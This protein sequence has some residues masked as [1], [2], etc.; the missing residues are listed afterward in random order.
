M[1]YAITP[2]RP[3]LAAIAAVLALSATPS[4]AQ[5]ALT[6]DVAPPAV[7]P[8]NATASGAG[9]AGPAIAPPQENAAP[10]LQ[11]SPTDAITASTTAPVAAQPAIP[12]ASSVTT[13][14]PVIA[15]PAPAA[16]VDAPPPPA[17]RTIAQASPSRSA[18]S[19]RV[20][21]GAVSPVAQAS[22]TNTGVSTDAPATPL[23]PVGASDGSVAATAALPGP[24][25]ATPVA[26]NDDGDMLPIAGAAGAALLLLGGGIYAATRRRR[27]EGEPAEAAYETSSAEIVA[28]PV[29]AAPVMAPPVI[30][31]AMSRTAASAPIAGSSLPAGFDLSRFGRHTQAAYR[32]PTPENPF[33][34]LRRR[35]KRASF[36]D[37]RERVAAAP[38]ATSMATP[39]DAPVAATAPVRQA[40]LVTTKIR[41]PQRPGFRPAFQ[42]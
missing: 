7:T 36:L 13:S 12:T 26:A 11:Q 38:A 35:L 39:Q 15:L 16:I 4:I 24:Q 40:G 37:A 41:M 14:T 1:R 18:A 22:P 23:A 8:D 27:A 19:G 28:P 29:A 30:A 25:A 10:V 20:N 5:E 17:A 34:S 31:P 3:G 6:L 2:V 21:S 9:D 33:L 42:G 32:G